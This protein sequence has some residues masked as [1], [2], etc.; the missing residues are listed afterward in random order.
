MT[1]LGCGS[2]VENIL[3]Q[4]TPWVQPP[5]PQSQRSELV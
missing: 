4:I 2:V 1:G 5:G 3:V